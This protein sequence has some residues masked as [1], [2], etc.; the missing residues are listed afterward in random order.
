MGARPL[1][2]SGPLADARTAVAFLTR[3]PV[4]DGR[5]LDAAGLSRAATWFPA[6]G[7]LVGGVLGGTRL[8]A[9]L[10]VDPAPAT[11]LALFAA[12]VITGG[13]HEDGLA[14][15]SDA[16]GA[17]VTRERRLE[18]LKD[19]RVGT[20]GG[21]A[22]VFMV[23][24]PFSVLVGLSGEDVLL[25]ALTAHVLGRWSVLP[26]SLLAAPARAGG[27]GT[28][29][30]ATPVGLAVTSVFAVAV[31]VLC[32]GVGPGLLAVGVAVVLTFGGGLVLARQFGGVTGDSFG[33][34]NKVVELATYVVLAAAW[35]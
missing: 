35:S 30:R 29:V 8:L 11:L 16:Y 23:L 21:L 24:L 28:L 27:S 5:T 7:L 26:H 4:S 14:D 15:V 32:A 13:F 17:H 18:I 33:A 9:D 25:A 2:V 3:I 12:I 6:V 10:A 31:A 20:Y 1:P 22:L 19:S 34:V